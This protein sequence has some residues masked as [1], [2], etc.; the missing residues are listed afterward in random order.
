MVFVE[1]QFI[2]KHQRIRD[3]LDMK[4]YIEVDDDIRLSRMG[5]LIHFIKNF[6]FIKF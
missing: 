1:G 5:I 3:L 6:E 2:F 4:I